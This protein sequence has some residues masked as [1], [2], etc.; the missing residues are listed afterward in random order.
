MKIAVF[1]NKSSTEYLLKYFLLKEIKIS[2]LITLKATSFEAGS[3]SGYSSGLKTVATENGINLIEVNDYSMR[4]SWT[5]GSQTYTKSLF[6]QANFKIL[7]LEI[8]T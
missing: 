8:Q 6:A 2:A 4:R 5:N 7:N 3:I 1:G